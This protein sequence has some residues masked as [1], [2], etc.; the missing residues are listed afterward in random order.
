MIILG[1]GSNISNNTYTREENI[2]TA[3]RL[4]SSHP[5][6]TIGKISHLYET[7]PVGL[8]EQPNFLNAVIEIRTDLSPLELLTVCLATERQMGRIRE[9]HWGPR[10]I[11]I[12]LLVYHDVEMTTSELELPHPRTPERK[13]VLIPLAEITDNA[14]IYR[15]KNAQELLISTPDDT[16]VK[17]YGEIVFDEQA[18]SI[19]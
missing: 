15:G 18:I 17:V 7:E 2:A 13:F 1:L 8:K 3:V 10:N 6:I 11:D 4:L 19:G 14:K 12:D 9:V 5:Q 16:Q